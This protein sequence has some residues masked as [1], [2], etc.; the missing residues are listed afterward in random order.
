M[1]LINFAGLNCYHGCIINAAKFLGIDY[2]FAFSNLW[3]ET[4]FYYDEKFEMFLTRR[5]LQNLDK[6]GL[7][8]QNMPCNA[9]ER[10]MVSFNSL[11]SGSWV[12]G[13]MDAFYMPW[14]QYFQTLKGYHYFL[15]K[16]ETKNLLTVF[17]PTYNQK[18]IKIHPDKLLPYITDFVCV[19]LHEPQ[20]NKH[21]TS[22]Y[23]M[24]N[25]LNEV[26]TSIMLLKKNMKKKIYDCTG[27]KRENANRLAAY[28][29]ALITNRYIYRHYLQNISIDSDILINLFDVK[30]FQEWT[31]VKNGLY[32]ASFIHENSDLLRQ[33]AEKFCA[34]CD[35][36]IALALLSF[37]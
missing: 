30:F 16:K 28:T 11:E 3:S 24:F 15:G 6:I 34:L 5:L 2:L 26:I 32:K 14:N 7:K 23:S 9:H 22:K 33:I 35:K 25:E 4:D 31:A 27:Q 1:D 8:L 12:I 17:D 13:G 36:E 19:K 29:N 18:N 20:K 10:A 37:N 21:Q